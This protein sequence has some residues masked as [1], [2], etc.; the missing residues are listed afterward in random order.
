MDISQE[1]LE[2]ILR[3]LCGGFISLIVIAA[4]PS[5]AVVP[6]CHGVNGL[7]LQGPGQQQLAQLPG[8]FVERYQSLIAMLAKQSGL[9]DIPG[10]QGQKRS[11]AAG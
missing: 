10:E 3:L 1:L 11:T 8:Y 6:V 9:A 2:Q 4:A 5:L 7:I